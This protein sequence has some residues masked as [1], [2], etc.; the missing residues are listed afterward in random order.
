MAESKLSGMT[1]NERLFELGVL[2]EF[3]AARARR[4]LAKMRNLLEKAEA[5][6]SSIVS[7]LS[8]A[9]HG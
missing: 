7:I 2:G 8:N 5:D 9:N 6:E 1:T 3:D 4:D